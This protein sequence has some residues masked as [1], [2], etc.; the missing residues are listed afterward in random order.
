MKLL[1]G[2]HHEDANTLELLEQTQVF[3]IPM[4]NPDGVA[5]I[6]ARETGDGK[7]V[8][9][10]KNGRQLSAHCSAVDMGVDLNRNYDVSWSTHWS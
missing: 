8:L 1:H 9:K 6:E 10:R 4:V 5:F 7:I 2:V 3:F